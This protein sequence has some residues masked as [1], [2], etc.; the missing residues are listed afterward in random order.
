MCNYGRVIPLK[1]QLKLLLLSLRYTFNIYPIIHKLIIQFPEKNRLLIMMNKHE[2]LFLLLNV[3][4]DILI[5]SISIIN[6][7]ILQSILVEDGEN[8]EICKFNGE[9]SVMLLI[10]YKLLIVFVISFLIFVEWNMPI[11]KYDIR[12][13]VSTIFID[14]LSIILIYIF[15]IIKINNYVFYFLLQTLITS[16][17][18]ISNY[19]FLYGFGLFLAFIKKQNIKLQFINNINEQFVNN[20]TQLKIKTCDISHIVSTAHC[21]SNITNESSKNKSQS[22][23]TYN[24]SNFI[25]RMID[26]HYQKSFSSNSLNTS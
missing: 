7:C 13:I 16:I 2:Y 20:E 26:Y 3:F 17:I 8:F 5:N 4:I 21:E 25:S 23:T 18:S 12:F 22:T 15:H 24:Q 11:I 1:C 10:V 14:A 6:G 9:Y 19:I